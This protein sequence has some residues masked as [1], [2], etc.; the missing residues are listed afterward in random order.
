VPI[1]LGN[2]VE[3]VIQRYS[4]VGWYDFQSGFSTYLDAEQGM[5]ELRPAKDYRIEIY[6]KTS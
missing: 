5:S 2:Q 4:A 1:D 3:F 6:S